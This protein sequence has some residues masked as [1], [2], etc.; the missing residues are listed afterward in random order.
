VNGVVLRIAAVAA[1]WAVIGLVGCAPAHT[2]PLS[3][4]PV[5][6]SAPDPG[7]DSGYGVIVTERPIQSGLDGSRDIRSVIMATLGNVTPGTA[8]SPPT[9]EFIV[10]EDGGRTIS[11]VQGNPQQLRPGDRVVIE[12]GARILLHRAVRVPV[13]AGG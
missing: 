5:A 2:L 9:T 11:V 3:P 10:R 7:G 1:P 13:A 4:V 12:Y 8:A 6:S